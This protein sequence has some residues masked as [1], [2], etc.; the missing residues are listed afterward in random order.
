MIHGQKLLFFFFFDPLA[1]VTFCV[2]F[3]GEIICVWWVITNYTQ[4]RED[5]IATKIMVTRHPKNCKTHNYINFAI[6]YYS[7][8]L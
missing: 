5:I 8:R 6:M 3:T 2:A 7:L 1:E 4:I